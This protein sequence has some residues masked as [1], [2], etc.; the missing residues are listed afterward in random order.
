VE[1]TPVSSITSD[2][3][4][5]PSLGPSS[6]E[7]SVPWL[8]LPPAAS[9]SPSPSGSPPAAGMPYGGAGASLVEVQGKAAS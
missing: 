5:D 8:E 4:S 1:V 9:S 6:F 2:G 3:S 7:S